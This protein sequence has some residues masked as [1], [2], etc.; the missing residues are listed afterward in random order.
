MRKFIV[1]TFVAL[2]SV[3][4]F[5]QTPDQLWTELMA[6]NQLFVKGGQVVY[7]SMRDTRTGLANGQNPPVAILSCADSRVPPEILFQKTLGQLFVLR[8]AGNVEDTFNVASLE[9]AVSQGWTKLIVV[10]GHTDCGAV[11]S[12]LT[13]PRPDQPTPSLH[14]LILRIRSSFTPTV[15]DL[16]TATTDHVCYTAMQFRRWSP[17]LSNVPIKTALYDLRTGAVTEVT[18]GR[19]RDAT[20]LCRTP[21]QP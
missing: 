3:S 1:G 16:A 5:A 2:L 6:G 14:D 4:A 11:S 9:Y 18:C 20:P 15:P 12:S 19:T 21:R 17:T 13:A 8:V 10:M 7:D